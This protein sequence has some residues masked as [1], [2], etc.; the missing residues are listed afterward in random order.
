MLLS[1]SPQLFE[2]FL[3]PVRILQF[4]LEFRTEL[5]VGIGIVSVI[6]SPIL[7]KIE[8]AQFFFRRIPQYEVSLKFRFNIVTYGRTDGRTKRF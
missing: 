1:S 8:A 4:T 3:F 5:L 7:T 2:T 6:F